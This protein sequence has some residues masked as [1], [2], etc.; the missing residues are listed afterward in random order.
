VTLRA[1]AVTAAPGAVMRLAPKR[2]QVAQRVVAHQHD[3]ATA[4]AVAAVGPATRNVGFTAKAHA[5][6]SAGA[7][8]DVDSRAIVQHRQAS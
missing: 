4:T 2:L 7:R 1:L 8:L 6:V 3:S 5:S